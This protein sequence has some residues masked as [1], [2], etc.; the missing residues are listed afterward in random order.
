MLCDE[1]L[2]LDELHLVYFSMVEFPCG[3]SFLLTL[4]GIVQD[5]GQLQNCIVMIAVL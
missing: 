2:T 4:L 3:E 5:F 1:N